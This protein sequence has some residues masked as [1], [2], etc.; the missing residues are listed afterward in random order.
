M[1]VLRLLRFLSTEM[2]ERWLFD[3]LFLIRVSPNNIKVILLSNEWQPCLFV[4]SADVVEEI[5]EKIKE[6]S[7]VKDDDVSTTTTVEED[8]DTSKIRQEDDI[9]ITKVN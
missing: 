7:N 2:K 9:S 8:H 6:I 4:I 5:S 1:G 3:I